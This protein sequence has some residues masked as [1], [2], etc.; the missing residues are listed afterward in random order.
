MEYPTIEYITSH[1]SHRKFYLNKDFPGFIE[2]L[3]EKYPDIRNLSEQLWLYFHGYTDRPHCSICGNPVKTFINFNQGY[4]KY[5]CPTCAQKDPEVRSKNNT[6]NIQRYGEDYHKKAVEKSR[7]TK[8]Q[9]YGDSNYNNP[10]KTRITCLEKFG[11]TNAMKSPDIVKKGEETCIRKYGAK[12]KILSQE[13]QKINRMRIDDKLKERYPEVIEVKNNGASFIC[14]CTDKS[15][16]KCLEKQFQIGYDLY[17]ERKF[18]YK[19]EICPIKNR[20]FFNKDTYIEKFIKDILST[21]NIQYI[22]NDRKILSGKEIDIYIPDHNLAIECN[23]IFWHS[24]TNPNNLPLTYHYDKWES[25][26]DQNIQLLSIWEDQIINKSEI[27]KGLVLS[28]LGIYDTRIQ[29]RQCSVKV[30]L[31]DETS[32]FLE[33]NHLQ[34]S[35]SGSIRYGLYYRDEL[36]SIMV[37]GRKR[38]A[39][40]SKDEKDTYELYRYCNKLGVHVIAGA[41]RLF[42]HFVKE[43]PNCVV[44]SFSSNDI[45]MGNLYKKLGFKLVGGQKFSY[46]YIDKTMQRHHRYTFRKDVLVKNGA[47]PSKTEFQITDELGLFRIY[48]SGQ[49]KWIYKS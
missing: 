44:E 10:E 28:K 13:Y 17:Y 7:Q 39:L 19:T 32:K 37:F 49:Q 27:I 1:I 24:T 41:S 11:V 45:S 2:F 40:G 3:G 35:I 16:D 31:Q 15:C 23:G 6:T 29:A 33:M 36:I 20:L 43:H 21:H 9:K 34:G 5:C 38:K 25:C 22:P 30:V 8:L 42:K 18:V 26:K 12:R 46:W 4:V 47:D 48:D 14:R